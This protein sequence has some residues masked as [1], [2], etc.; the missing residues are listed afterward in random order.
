MPKNCIS[1]VFEHSKRKW[2]NTSI[3]DFNEVLE[4]EGGKTTLKKLDMFGRFPLMWALRYNASDR[5]IAKIINIMAENEMAQIIKDPD[6]ENM[7]C[8]TFAHEY[9]AS[10]KVIEMLK[11]PKTA[12]DFLETL[13]TAGEDDVNVAL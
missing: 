9:N 2:E 13:Q 10:A 12:A 7:R 1:T 11:Y 3:D 6:Y 4:K 5:L 8:M